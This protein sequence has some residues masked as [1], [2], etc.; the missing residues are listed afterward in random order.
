MAYLIDYEGMALIT[1]HLSNVVTTL[2]TDDSYRASGKIASKHKLSKKN[3]FGI[4]ANIGS[5]YHYYTKGE[6]NGKP[7][8][9]MGIGLNGQFN[10][11]Y[12]AFRPEVYYDYI[13][14]YHP[15]GEIT[16]HG[17]TIPLNLILQT[18]ASSLSGLGIFAGPYY[19]H[20]FKGHQ[21]NSTSGLPLDFEN[22]Y[23]R[24]EVGY[25]WGIE[26]RVFNLRV[27]F[28]S[29]SA[30][31]NFSRKTNVDGAHIRNRTS[32]ATISYTF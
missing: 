4:S 26:M 18:P 14:A 19:S 8:S 20:K 22:I 13:K 25:N 30:L 31:T 15:Q 21:G 24:T 16:T 32:F 7:A 28:T 17:I 1:E 10:K 3:T 29:R 5:N 9:A 12:I 11:K 2:S 27:G 6:L 23:N